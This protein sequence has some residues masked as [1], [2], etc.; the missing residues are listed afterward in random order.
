MLSETFHFPMT[1][2][3]HPIHP[4]LF[5]LPQPQLTAFVGPS[6]F[7]LRTGRQPSPG[8]CRYP[9]PCRPRWSRF[10]RQSLAYSAKRRR[11]KRRTLAL[12]LVGMKD[13]KLVFAL[14]LDFTNSLVEWPLACGISA[15]RRIHRRLQEKEQ[16]RVRRRI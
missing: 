5:V 7:D 10:S 15:I 9:C 1:P 2:P 11:R 6:R 12:L 8:A 13:P 14:A 16:R 4:H 3:E